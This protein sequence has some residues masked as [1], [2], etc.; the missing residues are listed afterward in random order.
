M[1]I[2][3]EDNLWYKGKSD[4]LREF[5]KNST[6]VL[7][8]V[9]SRNFSGMPG[10]AVEALT[11][12]EMDS[13]IKLTDYNQKIMSDAIDREL[14]VLGLA[15]DISLKQ[16]AMAWELEK[17]QLYSDLQK[18][19][20]DKELTRARIEEDLNGLMIDQEFREVTVLLQKQAIEL[21]IEEVKRQK[22]ETELLPL[23]YEEALSAARLA[24]AQRKMTAIP[25]IM[26]ALAAQKVVLDQEAAVIMPGRT[27]K[28]T[29]DKET[30]DRTTSEVLPLMADKSAATSA[31]TLKQYELLPLLMAKA[32]ASQEL[33]DEMLAQL[34]NHKAIAQE[35][36]TMANEKINRLNVE[37]SLASQ[38][39]EL[40]RKKIQI[41]IDRSELELQR[42]EA[43]LSVIEEL[44]VQLGEIQT[45]MSAEA[46]AAIN[47]INVQGDNE[48]AIKTSKLNKV[49]AARYAAM[50]DDSAAQENSIIAMGMQDR[51]HQINM[52]EKNKNANITEKLIHLL[53]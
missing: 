39:L 14:K 51:Q 10:F 26:A 11:D 52:A 18:E 29:I 38:E 3:A 36:V 17:Q 6:A 44:R 7:S 13:K 16:A 5:K 50:D 33:A 30:A 40:D 28:A 8:T 24:T 32:T 47:L 9:A 12:I 35:K 1:G 34:D 42:A 43:R 49:D 31:L 41:E 15:D 4:V 53:A 19:F 22:E 27:E 2:L 37:L 48:I 23:P 20:S 45:A 25:Y 21:E 46:D